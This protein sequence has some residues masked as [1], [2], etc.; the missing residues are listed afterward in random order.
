MPN[1]DIVQLLEKKLDLNNIS[2]DLRNAF[3]TKMV[4]YLD[5]GRKNG[6]ING[7]TYSFIEDKINTICDFFDLIHLT[8]EEKVIVLSNMPSLLN[9]CDE[10]FNKYLLLGV[11]EKNGTNIRKEKL[12]NKTNDYRVSLESIYRRYMVAVNTGYSNITWNL[13]VHASNSEFASIFIKGKHYKTYQIFD[14][15]I[16]LESYMNSISVDSLNIED[17]KEWDSNREIMEE[18]EKRLG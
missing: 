1:Q 17:I 5:H 15:L 3:W 12:V 14:S 7:R 2:D 11:I 16:A 9:T 6:I 10:L 4:N 8:N 13:L 18:Y